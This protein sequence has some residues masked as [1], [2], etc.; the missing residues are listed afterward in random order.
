LSTYLD[1][2]DEHANLGRDLDFFSYKVVELRQG[3]L[4]YSAFKRKYRKNSQ[5]WIIDDYFRKRHSLR[6]YF[7]NRLM[8]Y[9]SV[10]RWILKPYKIE[11]EELD[12][13]EEHKMLSKE[14]IRS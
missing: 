12:E 8:G 1:Y 14:L 7:A 13:A 9:S 2:L 5:H 10:Q 3:I 11:E 6:N 4:S